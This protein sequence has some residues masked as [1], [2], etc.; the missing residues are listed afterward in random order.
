LEL[1][2]ETLNWI[3]ADAAPAL[4]PGELHLW[5]I[6]CGPEGPD[7]E[8]LWPVLSARE[9][10]RAER[11]HLARHQGRYVRA[12]SGL[13]HILAS[14]INIAPEHIVFN[15]GDAGKPAL[16]NE[17]DGIEL[18]LTTSD[19]LALA[20]ICRDLPVGIDCEQLRLRRNLGAIARRMFP[21]ETAER[22]AKA[23][24]EERLTVFTVA[25]T[26][27]EARVKADGRGLFRRRDVPPMAAFQVAHCIPQ[28]GFIAALA[29]ADLP[30]VPE[31][32]TFVLE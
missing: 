31:W 18:N 5:K 25:W 10:A 16:A 22:V 6:P 29:R 4:R 1:H 20:A 9:R 23:S 12:H 32:R 28:E 17:A 21:P 15:Y 2:I 8:G 24:A 30:P 14:Y 11:L 13:R 7:L 26:A 19:D 3:P 27:L